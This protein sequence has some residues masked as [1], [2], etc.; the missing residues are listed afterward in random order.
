[1]KRA[2]AHGDGEIGLYR[3]VTN[4]DISRKPIYLLEQTKPLWLP[5]NVFSDVCQDQT[6]PSWQILQSSERRS[7]A[8]HPKPV[9]FSSVLIACSAPWAMKF[10][11]LFVLSQNSY[12]VPLQWGTNWNPAHHSQQKAMGHES[13]PTFRNSFASLLFTNPTKRLKNE[14][15]TWSA[16]ESGSPNNFSFLWLAIIMQTIHAST[17]FGSGTEELFKSIKWLKR[18][19]AARRQEA[20]ESKIVLLIKHCQLQLK[21]NPASAHPHCNLRLSKKATRRNRDDCS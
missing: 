4:Q 12:L 1:M 7:L 5:G 15:K 10:L 9:R 2:T 17:A 13:P 6:P 16:R 19:E 11:S 18:Q 20:L 8:L 3:K 21:N 14:I